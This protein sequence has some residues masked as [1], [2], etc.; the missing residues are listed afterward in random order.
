MLA[1]M[2]MMMLHQE[3]FVRGNQPDLLKMIDI[4]ATINKFKKGLKLV[5]A[6]TW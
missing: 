3:Y 5:K 1:P 4:K 2:M 6:E